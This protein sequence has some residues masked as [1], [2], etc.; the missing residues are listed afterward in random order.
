MRTTDIICTGCQSANPEDSYSCAECGHVLRFSRTPAPAPGYLTDPSDAAG[1]PADQTD[2][3]RTASPALSGPRDEG[4][5]AG[6]DWITTKNGG[7][8]RLASLAERA[9]ARVLDTLLVSACCAAIVGVSVII[10]ALSSTATSDFTYTTGSDDSDRVEAVTVFAGVFLA[11]LIAIAYEVVMVAV[12]GRTLGK[13]LVGLSIIHTATG[14][15]PPIGSA[16][17]RW[18]APGVGSLIP[19]L[20]PIGGVVVY[21]SPVFDKSGLRQGWHDR[22]ADTIVTRTSSAV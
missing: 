9:G 21:L 3:V 17:L 8:H 7:R 19:I 2:R 6:A 11:A 4:V 14:K 12:C 15:R 20:V 5:P 10:A 16:A 13:M 1:H 22:L 18:I